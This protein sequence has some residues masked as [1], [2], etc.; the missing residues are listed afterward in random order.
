M[1]K[2][3]INILVFYG[4]LDIVFFL[5]LYMAAKRRFMQRPVLWGLLAIVTSPLIAYLILKWKFKRD[6]KKRDG[7]WKNGM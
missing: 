5:G 7:E 2:E 3:T 4:F 6:M 1:N